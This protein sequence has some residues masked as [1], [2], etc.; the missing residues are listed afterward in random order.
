MRISVSLGKKGSKQ[1][2]KSLD[3][4]ARSVMAKIT[5]DGEGCPKPENWR[6]FKV[7]RGWPKVQRRGGAGP[8]PRRLMAKSPSYGYARN[9]PFFKLVR[10]ARCLNLG[11][12]S[13]SEAP[14]GFWC[15]EP[16]Q[17][18][19]PTMARSRNNPSWLSRIIA[20]FNK[21]AVATA[22][23]EAGSGGLRRGCQRGRPV[24]RAGRGR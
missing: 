22:P 2:V 17:N 20:A 5:L 11:A 21:E 14:C 15:R 16:G 3:G 19:T 24:G 12:S 9:W 4:P 10:T 18:H 13:R 8:R 6:I 7:A 1:C 23:S